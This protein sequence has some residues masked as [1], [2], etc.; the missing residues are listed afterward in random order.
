MQWLIDIILELIEPMLAALKVTI[1]GQLGAFDRGNVE[2]IDFTLPF[3]ITDNAW[4]DLDLSAIVPAGARFVLFHTYI[5][6]FTVGKAFYIQTKGNPDAHNISR[7]EAQ[8][9]GLGLRAD[10][11]CPVNSNR[12]CEYRAHVGGWSVINLTVKGWWLR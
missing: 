10:W 2:N 12:K 1:H 4:H 7:I 3:F 5:K 9:S 6:N 8:I 11:T